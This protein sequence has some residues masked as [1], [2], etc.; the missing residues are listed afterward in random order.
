MLLHLLTCY[1]FCQI[2][3]VVKWLLLVLMSILLFFVGFE[4]LPQ[5]QAVLD[6][7]FCAL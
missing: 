4:L 2:H 6:V 5:S 1:S 7:W 3:G